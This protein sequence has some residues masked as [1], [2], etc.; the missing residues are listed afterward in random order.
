MLLRLEATRRGSGP[1]SERQNKGGAVRGDLALVRREDSED[2]GE[3]RRFDPGRLRAAA[4][5]F[6]RSWTV[7]PCRSE[8]GRLY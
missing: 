8:A 6:M 3:G 5:L 1:G 7:F 4:V 2:G